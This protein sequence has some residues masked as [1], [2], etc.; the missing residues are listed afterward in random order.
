MP[1]ITLDTLIQR[2]TAYFRRHAKKYGLDPE[3]VQARYILNW[4]GFVNASFFI[5]DGQRRY[6]LK[7]SAD[8]SALDNLAQWVT[9]N[10]H[11]TGR[12]HA[13]R[14]LDYVEIPR[15]GGFQGPLLE[16]IPGKPADLA[17]RPEVLRGVLDLLTALHGDSELAAALA[18]YRAGLAEDYD[19]PPPPPMTC[20]DYFLDVYID[21][22]DGDLAT[23]AGELPPFVPLATLD[24]MMGETR[25]LEGLARDLP[26][27]H[28]PAGSP[29]HGDLY[30]ENILVTER[31][32]WYLIDWDDLS[33]GD[34]ALEYA[35]LLDGLLR[36]GALS[37]E[38]AEALLP[39]VPYQREDFLTRFRVCLRAQ[40]LD[41]VI[42]S[43]ADWVESAFAPIHQEEVRPAKQRAHQE[44]L[45][46]YQALYPL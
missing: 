7:L 15:S 37:Q 20:T 17:A 32:D 34:P 23:I 22:L 3:Q 26:A 8:E 9:L 19:E 2:V 4:G 21:R 36:S 27:F 43:L 18:D 33:L 45:Q 25:E 40:L 10:E 14:M 39:V 29:V 38:A 12:Y 41:T 44:A 16:Y 30:P 13:P 28:H 11:L 5:Q 46:R 6:H 1:Q 31:G 24:W 42:D 35:I